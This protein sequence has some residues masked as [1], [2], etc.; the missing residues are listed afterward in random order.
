MITKADIAMLRGGMPPKCDFCGTDTPP[1]QL[2][3]EEAGDWVCW[4]CLRRW[5]QEDGDIQVEAFWERAIKE[6]ECATGLH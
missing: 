5:A 4:R 1:E 2:E 3:P 6:A